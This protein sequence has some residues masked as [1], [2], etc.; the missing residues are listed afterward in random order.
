MI[1]NSHGGNDLKPFLREIAGKTKC[2][3]FS[4][5]GIKLIATQ[6]TKS[7]SILMIT[8]AKWKLPHLHFRPDLVV[9]DEAGKLR[10]DAGDRRPMQFEALNKGWVSFKPPLALAHHQLRFWKSAS[11][12]GA[13]GKLLA[14]AVVERIAP[15]LVEL[16]EASIDAS[17][18]FVP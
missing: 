4:A 5:T 14:D 16:S 7:A 3:F 12:F 18:P 17:F 9:H 8:R 13:K 6:R 10:A 1:F 15:F 2:T 11:S